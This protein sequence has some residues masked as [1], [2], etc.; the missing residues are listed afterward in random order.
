MPAF[1]VKQAL[2]SF[3]HPIHPPEFSDESPTVYSDLWSYLRWQGLIYG[4]W[5]AIEEFETRERLI[6]LYLGQWLSLLCARYMG[7]G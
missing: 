3:L 2:P 6:K 5:E 1:P 4:Q 7:R